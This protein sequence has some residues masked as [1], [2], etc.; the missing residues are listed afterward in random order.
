LK[1]YFLEFC[2]E[3]IYFCGVGQNS[4]KNVAEIGDDFGIEQLEHKKF[5][6]LILIF[7]IMEGTM[8]TPSNDF[9]H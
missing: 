6:R 9:C 4:Y 1:V 8:F 2:K 3:E 5:S 7:G